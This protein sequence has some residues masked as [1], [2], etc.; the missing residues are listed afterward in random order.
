[1]AGEDFDIPAVEVLEDVMRRTNLGPTEVARKAGLDPGTATNIIQ[2]RC[3]ATRRT[4]SKLLAVAGLT[5]DQYLAAKTAGFP[6]S[7]IELGVDFVRSLDKKLAAEHDAC[8]IS[9]QESAA[10]VEAILD[11][12]AN[13]AILSVDPRTRLSPPNRVRDGFHSIQRHP[14]RHRKRDPIRVSVPAI[15]IGSV[16]ALLAVR[17]N[18]HL[19]GHEMSIDF[20][21]PNGADQLREINAGSRPY[22]FAVFGIASYSLASRRPFARTLDYQLLC[23]IHSIRQ[24]T[25]CLPGDE[26]S[27]KKVL[28]CPGGSAEFQSRCGKGIP[29]GSRV[30][31]VDSTSPLSLAPSVKEGEAII[32]FEPVGETIRERHGLV[33]VPRSDFRIHMGLFV[34]RMHTRRRGDWVGP[35]ELSYEFLE[36]FAAEYQRLRAN[37][38]ATLDILC[39][40]AAFRAAY[41]VAAGVSL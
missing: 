29:A 41:S 27:V 2:R 26:H 39:G 30:E 13:A 36:A 4:I 12:V 10:A 24:R 31:E 16:A 15:E 7:R 40:D 11:D 9:K 19:Y 3:N 17:A 25:F 23:P 6:G 14:T 21:A 1:M 38:R 35:T 34:N 8:T 37:P 32:A 20:A 28:V 33:R 22:D 18:I 5:F